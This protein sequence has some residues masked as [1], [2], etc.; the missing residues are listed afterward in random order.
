MKPEVRWPLFIVGLL[1][2]QVLLGIFFFWQATSD[3]SFAVEENYYQKGVEWDSKMAQDRANARLGW[4]AQ[5]TVAPGDPATLEVTLRDGRG[6]AISEAQVSIE[7]FHNIRAG[8]ILRAGLSE[9]T[10]T[11][12]YRAELP[13]NRPG[14]WEVRITAVKAS[15][16]FTHTART[17]VLAAGP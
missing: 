2:A 9:T 13:M 5:V 10:P 14:I 12:I 6:E 7:T 3:P 17:Y 11:G 1:A 16:T 15:A 8:D 4:I